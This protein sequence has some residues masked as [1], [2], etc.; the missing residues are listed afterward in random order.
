MGASSSVQKVPQTEMAV[1]TMSN[2]SIHSLKFVSPLSTRKLD[3]FAQNM[4]L[5]SPKVEGLCHVLSSYHGKEAFMKF[6]RNEW[7]LSQDSHYL[8]LTSS[9][10]TIYYHNISLCNRY[11]EANLWFYMAIEEMKKGYRGDDKEFVAD[12]EI[13]ISTYL[14]PE[15]DTKVHVS[16]V[17]RENL[18]S[19]V[20]GE[21]FATQ[22]EV[23]SSPMFFVMTT[24]YECKQVLLYKKLA[25]YS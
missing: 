9:V 11:A 23:R 5:R 12:T 4:F 1:Q 13:L 7:V 24:A 2:N 17:L 22:S 19:M 6:L 14:A 16:D 10:N 18:Q 3:N 20:S 25:V 15:S 8:V 21:A